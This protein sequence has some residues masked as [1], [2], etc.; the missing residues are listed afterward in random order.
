MFNIN[1]FIVSQVNP[2]VVPFLSTFCKE[3]SS[4]QTFREEFKTDAIS[5]ITSELLYR[6]DVCI[7]CGIFPNIFKKARGILS[8]DYRGDI[9]ILPTI[10][11]S[12]ILK[13]WPS[14][15]PKDL[16]G[17]C[18]KCERATWP[19]LSHI[20]ISCAIELALDDV[21]LTLRSKIVLYGS[22]YDLPK[23]PVLKLGRAKKLLPSDF[24]SPTNPVR[25]RSCDPRMEGLKGL[26]LDIIPSTQ[27]EKR[28]HIPFGHMAIEMGSKMQSKVLPNGSRHKYTALD[29]TSS[30]CDSDLETDESE[31]DAELNDYQPPAH[32]E[33]IFN[34]VDTFQ[35]RERLTGTSEIP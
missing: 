15:Y 34:P 28:S 20:R 13:G 33:R 7:E 23:Y 4:A 30:D 5:L 10:A 14:Q 31:S 21:V 8:Q 29:Y 35:S 11:L 17:L 9:T 1:H 32:E 3:S 25:A 2:Y 27:K 12:E 6:F 19:Y 16:V 26:E 24:D 18:L 22:S